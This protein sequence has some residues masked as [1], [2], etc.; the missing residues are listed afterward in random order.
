MNLSIVPLIMSLSVDGVSK[1]IFF[2]FNFI[3]N[4]IGGGAECGI[5]RVS[6]A[7]KQIRGSVLGR[8]L[9]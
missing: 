8:G 1:K 9:V 2:K 5:A 7:K 6:H 4:Q 3:F